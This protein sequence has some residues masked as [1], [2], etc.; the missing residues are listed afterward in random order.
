MILQ[1]VRHVAQG[2]ELQHLQPESPPGLEGKE[3][4]GPM[5]DLK[6]ENFE[7]V[8]FGSYENH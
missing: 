2:H 4:R 7:W 6:D 8:E 3:N 5:S 1:Q